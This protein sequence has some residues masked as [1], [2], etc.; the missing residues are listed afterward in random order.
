MRRGYLL[1][2]AHPLTKRREPKSTEFLK[3]KKNII[4]LV[5][6]SLGDTRF[7]KLS[8]IPLR[9]GDART[10]QRVKSS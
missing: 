2:N 10:K 9:N 4:T 1:L 5:S 7:L 8:V 3:W 6:K